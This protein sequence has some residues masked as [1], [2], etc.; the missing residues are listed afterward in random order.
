MKPAGKLAKAIDNGSFVMTAE[1][2]PPAGTDVSDGVNLFRGLDALTAVNVADNPFGPVISSMAASN[3]LLEAGI[4][5]VMQMVTRDRNRIALQSDLLGA[6]SLG[7]PN[8]LCLSGY[9]QTIEASPAAKNVHDIDSIQLLQAVNVMN[10]SGVL[11]EGTSIAGTFAMTA[12]ASAN[13]S[14]DPLELNIIRL[15][16]KITAGAAFIQTQAV[17]DTDRFESWMAAVRD[18]GLAEKTAVI[19]GVMPLTSAEEAVRLAEMYTDF[20]IPDETIGRLRSAGGETEQRAAGIAACRETIERLRAIDGVR[21]IHIMCGGH[22]NLLAGI[23][24]V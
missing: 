18:A 23:L 10:E 14:T 15:G 19:A 13:P 24:G 11:I 20:V 3:A 22:E 8:I 7:I 1:F 9:H 2:L 6:A 5:P 17:F 16:K 21:G 12:G 4:E